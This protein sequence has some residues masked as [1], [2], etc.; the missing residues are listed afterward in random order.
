MK[1]QK[2][3]GSSEPKLSKEE[4]ER[5]IQE[6]VDKMADDAKLIRMGP[7]FVLGFF[8][9]LLTTVVGVTTYYWMTL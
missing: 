3:K 8:L 6:F 7:W 9:I 4:Q 2:Q 1:M 5:R